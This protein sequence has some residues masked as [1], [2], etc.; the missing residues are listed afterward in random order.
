MNK[1]YPALVFDP[2]YTKQE[3]YVAESFIS[4]LF[5][6]LTVITFS[7]DPDNALW[8]IGDQVCSILGYT[9]SRKALIDHV[10]D[11]DKNS[12]TIR[13]GIP[14]NPN[15]TIINEAGLYQLI[16]SSTMPNARQFQYWV[17]SEVLP[18]M[19]KA[20]FTNS[21]SYIRQLEDISM[22]LKKE[23]DKATFMCKSYSTMYDNVKN[24]ILNAV[25]LTEDQKDDMLSGSISIN[26]LLM[27]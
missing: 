4:E 2:S 10:Y 15:R 16:F 27:A 11:E 7:N 5:G 6:D 26:D 8:F 9:N 20:G 22:Q 24:K 13:Y 21:M 19:R 3:D 17:T 14:G 12:V 1:V 25:Y 23:R 18:S